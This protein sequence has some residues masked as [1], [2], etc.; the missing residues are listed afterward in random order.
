MGWHHRAGAKTSLMAEYLCMLAYTVL[1]SGVLVVVVFFLDLVR[2][3]W[4]K[5]AVNQRRFIESMLTKAGWKQDFL[6][7]NTPVPVRVC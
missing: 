1:F 5:I 7:K 2:V 6:V 3:G 4:V